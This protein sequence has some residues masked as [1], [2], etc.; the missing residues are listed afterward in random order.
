MGA[1]DPMNELR[2]HTRVFFALAAVLSVVG[3]V[4]F[5]GTGESMVELAAVVVFIAAAMRYVALA[6]RD[7]DVTSKMVSRRGLMGGVDDALASMA[8]EDRARRRRRR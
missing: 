6:V 2:T 3:F 5:H 8:A 4:V 7:D 1:S